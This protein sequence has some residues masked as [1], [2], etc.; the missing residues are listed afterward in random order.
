MRSYVE[1]KIKEAKP[2]PTQPPPI[3]QEP[4]QE[5]LIDEPSKVSNG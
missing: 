3:Q 5:Q 1:E 2:I 4:E